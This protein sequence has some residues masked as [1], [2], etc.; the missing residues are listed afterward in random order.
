MSQE[1]AN[2]SQC[3][4]L[5]E[6]LAGKA[7]AELMSSLTRGINPG[8]FQRTSDHTADGSWALEPD[9]WRIRTQKHASA[10]GMRPPVSQVISDSF[11]NIHGEGQLGMAAPLST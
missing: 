10:G 3:C 4:S 5:T 1:F 9:D 6:H 2:L 8:P 7:M 11:A